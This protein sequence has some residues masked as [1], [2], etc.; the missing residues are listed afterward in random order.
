VLATGLRLVSE[1]DLEQV[2]GQVHRL[3]KLC[4]RAPALS[5]R[6]LSLEDRAWALA[7][8]LKAAEPPLA[9]LAAMEFARLAATCDLQLRSQPGV[10]E[11]CSPLGG[12]GRAAGGLL[13]GQPGALPVYV[14]ASDADEEGF[15][16]VNARSGISVHVGPAPRHGT[17]ARY[18]VADAGEVIRLVHWIADA[19]R[20]AS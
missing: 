8:H 17:A 20:R 14:G 10:L 16:A 13:A 15:T 7:L 6:G 2:A 19:R 9:A 3:R 4:L 1:P 18:M 12:L 11:A 5:V